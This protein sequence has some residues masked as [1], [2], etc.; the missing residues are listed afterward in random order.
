MTQ[1]YLAL[2]QVFK[3]IN[4]IHQAG[5]ILNWDA[6][7]FMP[8]GSSESRGEQLAMLSQLAHQRLVSAENSSL[9]SQALA[10]VEK[11]SDWQKANLKG[12]KH[13]IDH[14]TC[15]S[16]ELVTQLTIASNDCEMLWRKYRKEN[17]Y[18]SLLPS[19]KKVV[20]LTKEIASIKAKH[21]NVSKYDALLDT[22]D[23]SRKSADIDIIFNQLEDFLPNFI[24]TA[25]TEKPKLEGHFPTHLQKELGLYFMG[26]FGFN[27]AKGRLD[28]SA[29]PFCGGTPD[30][31][32]ITTRYNEADFL[33][34]FYG[35][36]HETGHALY[37]ANLPKEW[38]HQPVGQAIGMSS[39]ESQSLLVEK[40]I[41]KSKEFIE[42]LH[43]KLHQYF[44]LS[45]DWNLEN[46]IKYAQHVS[47]SL[48]RV[49][50]DEATYPLHVIMRYKIEKAMIDDDLNLEDLPKIWND[51]MQKYFGIIPD[52]DANGC[53][54]D[55]HWFSGAIG[56]FPTYTL[57]AL[58]AAQLMAKLKSAVPNTPDLIKHGD[59][60]PIFQWLKDNIH[61]KGS[62]HLANDLLKE[63]SGEYLNP[64]YFMDHVTDRYQK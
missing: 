22:Y 3:D 44:N 30:D 32:R 64:Q 45:S 37:E 55:I 54:Q 2:E 60:A 53:M 14:N 26:L 8:E 49:E 46:L 11:L 16:E 38:R 43:P 28:E 10:N 56:Y 31:I 34:A 40:Q 57:G 59:F 61:S 63:A 4:I 41:C 52:S 15:I 27:F 5:A 19:F 48:I 1:A 42:F 20:D 47:P 12:M 29:H 18:K 7:T 9:L 24:K 62:F 50:A 33:Q 17:D 51:Y 58:T 23:P 21:F 35:V 25:T 6:S 36:V 13:E 39:H